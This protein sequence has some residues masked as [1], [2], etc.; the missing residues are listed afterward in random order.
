[1]F[2]DAGIPAVLVVEPGDKRLRLLFENNF[3][4]MENLPRLQLAEG[5]TSSLCFNVCGL[6]P[7]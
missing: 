1:V 6:Y 3:E 7:P 2:S 4:K 5:K